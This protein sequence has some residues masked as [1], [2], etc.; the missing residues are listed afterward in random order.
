MRPVVGHSS[1]Y[2]ERKFP[3]GQ[4][5]ERRG[6]RAQVHNAMGKGPRGKLVSAGRNASGTRL[7]RSGERQQ[8]GRGQAGWSSQGGFSVEEGCWEGLLEEK[9]G[10]QEAP[11]GGATPGRCLTWGAAAALWAAASARVARTQLA[12]TRN[13]DGLSGAASTT[14]AFTDVV[15]RSMPRVT[16]DGAMAVGSS[17]GLVAAEVPPLTHLTQD[18]SAKTGPRLPIPEPHT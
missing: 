15:P 9:E 12:S 13:P 6:Q 5:T 8:A 18:P 7:N 10:C 1:L 16:D 11:G 17:V 3:A 14:A 2:K 4:G